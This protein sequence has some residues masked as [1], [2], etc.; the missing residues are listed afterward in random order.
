MTKEDAIKIFNTLL[1]LGRC[2]CQKKEIEEC[3]KMAIKALEQ[4]SCETHMIDK[5]N[6]SQEQYKADLQSAYDCG[7]ASVKPCEDCIS[8]AELKK[9]LDMN[10][11]FGGAAR[12]I[13]LFDRL[14]KELPP[15]TPTQKWI[16]VS[17]RLPNRDEYIKNNGLFNVSDGNRSYSEWFDIYDKKMFGEPTMSSFRVDRAVIAWMPLPKPYEPQAERGD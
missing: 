12:K 2:D 3:L 14:D 8:R 15:V 17:E 9:W 1:L 5:S 11:D 4:E 6:F 10:F 13:E 16:P 7:R